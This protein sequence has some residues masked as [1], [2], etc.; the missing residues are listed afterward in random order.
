MMKASTSSTLDQGGN[1]T[2][3]L[4]LPISVAVFTSFLAPYNVG[5]FEALQQRVRKLTVLLCTEMES[6]RTWQPNFGSLDVRMIRTKT[7]VRPP[8]HSLG[9][10]DHG[11]VHFPRNA[12]DVLAELQPDIVI[13]SEL[14]MRSVASARYCRK[15]PECR[16]ILW[17]NLSEHTERE[18][19]WLRHWLRRWLLPQ[20]DAVTANGP[21]GER[22]LQR[23]GVPPERLFRV[24]YAAVPHVFDQ[25]PL[26]RDGQAQHRLLHLGRLIDLKGVMPFLNALIRYAQQHPQRNLEFWLAGDGPVRAQIEALPRPQNLSVQLLGDQP[27]HRLAEIC[28]QCGILAYPTLFDEWG[29]VVNEALA[30]GLPVLGSLYSQAV[31]T[32]VIPGKTGWTFRTDHPAE[33]DLAI[34][35]ALETNPADLDKMRFAGRQEVSHVTPDYAADGFVSAIRSVWKSPTT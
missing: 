24:P 34:A 12:R 35:T 23:M 21:S 3:R 22:Y 30:A 2:L 19:G 32:H 8:K 25:V 29:L 11:I 6:N 10:R 15:H 5:V 26:E 20:A 33:M 16:L 27:Y 1:R 9:F 18:R 28:Q 31:E 13:S 14:G 17:Q 4:P 7:I